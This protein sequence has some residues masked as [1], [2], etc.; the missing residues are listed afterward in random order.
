MVRGEG[1]NAAPLDATP[2]VLEGVSSDIKGERVAAGVA[3]LSDG[4]DTTVANTSGQW[5]IDRGEGTGESIVIA[6]SRSGG[7]WKVSRPVLR[8]PAT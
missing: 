4:A 5:S 6:F 8:R 3:A 7:Q 1:F 2:Y